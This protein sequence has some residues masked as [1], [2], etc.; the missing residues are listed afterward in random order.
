MPQL[1]VLRMA[2]GSTFE[3]AGK[4]FTLY[5]KTNDGRVYVAGFVWHR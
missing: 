2:P 1:K 4:E 3:Y 5:K